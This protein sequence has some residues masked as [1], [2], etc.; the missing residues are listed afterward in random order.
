LAYL[1][2]EASR[3]HRREALSA[4]FWP[5]QPEA[6]ARANLRQTLHRLRLAIE[7][8][9][10][11][12]P[13]LLVSVHDVQLDPAGDHWL[14][15]AEFERYV[16]AYRSHCGLGLPLCAVCQEALKAAV[17][18]YQGEFMAGFSVP[19]SPDFEF[20]LLSRQE[21]YHRRALEV[22]GRLGA[23]YEETGAFSQAV[24][25]AQRLVGLEPGRQSF[26]RLLMRNLVQAGQREAAMAQYARCRQLLAEDLGVEPS[27][28]TRRLY[29]L[30]RDRDDEALRHRGERES[31]G[32]PVG[33]PERG[34]VPLSAGRGEHTSP[35]TFVGRED[36]LSKLNA[37]LSRA[38]AG[39]GRVVFIC[40]EAGSGKSTLATEF[41]RRAMADEERLLLAHGACDTRLGFGDPYQPFRELLR[42]LSGRADNDPPW[43]P[44]GRESARRLQEAKSAIRQAL[45]EAGPD[46]PGTLLP[47]ASVS[48]AGARQAAVDRVALF[49]QVT[50]LLRAVSRRWPLLLVLDD[51]HWIDNTSASL[52]F[53]L[54]RHLADS[55]IL[56]I[57]AYRP[58]ELGGPDRPVPAASR[59]PL[60]PVI[61][62]LQR[63]SGANYVDLN[64]ADGRAF[65]EALVDSEPNRLGA[66]FR[67]SLHG[68]TGGNPLF[69]VEILRGLQ[70]RG[71]LVKD[72]Q[73]QW[74]VRRPL[75]WNQLPP[76]VEA[77]IGERFE[78]L[79]GRCQALLTAASV[80]GQTFL[81]EVA[82]D[83]RTF[84]AEPA[85]TGL[86]EVLGRQYHLVEASELEWYGDRA[87]SRY[88]FRHHLFQ[89]YA[90]QQMDPVA[91]SRSHQITGLTLE[92][93]YSGREEEHAFE[94]AGH[95]EAAGMLE[96]AVGYLLAAG[97][98]AY[99]LSANESALDYFGR[100]LDLLRECPPGP[101]RDRA[102]MTLHLAR[103]APLLAMRG[104]TAPEIQEA[105]NRV[106]HLSQ[107][108]DEPDYLFPARL[109]LLTHYAMLAEYHPAMELAEQLLKQAEESRNPLHLT[110]AHHFLGYLEFCGGS[111]EA[112]LNHFN[113]ALASYDPQSESRL[114]SG[115]I[116]QNV[117]LT[118]LF[119]KAWTLWFLGYP[120]QSLAAVEETMTKV[121]QLGQDHDL[122]FT[123]AIGICPILC[124]RREFDR[125]EIQTKHLLQLASRKGLDYFIPFGK[126]NLGS[127]LVN[128][129]RI[130]EG[131]N[132]IR[133]GVRQYSEGGQKTFLTFCLSLL[134]EALGKD[135]EAGEVLDEALALVEKTGERFFE[136]ELRRLRGEFLLR[137]EED[138]AESEACFQQALDIASQQGAKSLQLRAATS[139]AEL[140]SSNGRSKEAHDLLAGVYDSFGEGFATADLQDAQTLLIELGS[141]K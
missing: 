93:L 84:D 3:S 66:D 56:I 63:I 53:H 14:D 118:S 92:T 110:Q 20:W 111:F 13:H 15:V 60:L 138:P 99:R 120:D 133:T 107:K 82:A 114:I 62:G 1:A 55:R 50:G 137:R 113:A 65:V 105:A 106:I 136:A 119:R 10:S 49:E 140:W 71:E 18:L 25:C 22:L 27:E 16:T 129:G 102:E 85:V 124:L 17:A 26:H 128:R 42:Q 126:V 61:T 48:A 7:D 72:E 132:E 104:Y 78:R 28:Q 87:L 94:L 57:G 41:G 9:E 127:V 24:G 6:A 45:V 33:P 19:G 98:A 35:Q 70:D 29:E 67:T 108:L 44:A 79:T 97:R 134:I 95:F 122:A 23:F 32:R 74:V 31:N 30:I 76:R 39:R 54:G 101:K 141:S 75:D 123:L 11:P 34:S 77:V 40:G 37:H 81:A 2:V 112:A 4:L 116:G 121:E 38:L 89:Q 46:L 80:Q 73:A 21:R 88:R 90:Y 68:H 52:L 130:A 58:E 47:A 64:Q 139:L 83:T 115:F 5:D 69:A 117:W 91:R 43:E 51:L 59:H 8:V 96:K 100:A 131:Q 86:S 135:E 103:T 125:A 12:N 109:L 36:E